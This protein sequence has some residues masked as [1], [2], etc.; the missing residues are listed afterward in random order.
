MEVEQIE[1]VRDFNRY[2][3]QRLG[4]L[5]DRYLGQGRPFVQARL[6]FEIGDGGSLADLRARFDMDAGYLTRQLSELDDQGLVTVRDQA[7]ELTDAGRH[8]CAEL[9]QRA[10]AGI[11][12]LLGELTAGQRERLVAAQDEIR[13][14]LRAAAV[15]VEAVAP[16]AP[17][18][19]ECLAR[20]AAELDALF[21]EGFAATTLTRPEDVTGTQLLALEDGR[22]VGCGMW[23]RLGPGVA[24]IRHLWVADETRGLGL[25]RKLLSRLEVDAANHGI[26]IIRLGTHPLLTEALALYRSSGYA[27]IGKYS[28]VPYN[29]LAFEKVL[30]SLGAAPVTG[31]A[32]G[33]SRPPVA[34]AFRRGAVESASRR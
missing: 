2:Y 6:L 31:R 13:R 22:P 9:E 17:A 29:Q 23:I 26:S 16:A 3:T 8:E 15:T 18:A 7:A 25:G 21:P 1:R 4:V 24:E 27:D 33:T 14:V 20:Y 10:A 12:A 32:D 19:R 11:A 28:D 30:V 34:S 5:T